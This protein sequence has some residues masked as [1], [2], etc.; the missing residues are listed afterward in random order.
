MELVCEDLVVKGTCVCFSCVSC[1]YKGT[2]KRIVV[3]QVSCV[4]ERNVDV[5]LNMCF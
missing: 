1:E 5:W 4:Y 3:Y 2:Q